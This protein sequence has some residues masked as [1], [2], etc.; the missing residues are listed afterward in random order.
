[1]SSRT[2][3][4][5]VRGAFDVLTADQRATLLADAA[6]HDVAYAAFSP[7]GSIT[8]DIATRPFFT[9]RYEGTAAEDKDIPVVTAEAEA[10]AEQWLTS[11]GYA[12]KNLTSQTVDMSQTPLGSR[13]RRRER[14]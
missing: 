3:R 7:A 8:Y 4:V 11:R 1:M 5:T 13:G 2:I 14:A 10:A 12:F 9:F 6:G